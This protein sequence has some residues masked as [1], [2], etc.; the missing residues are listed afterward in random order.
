MHQAGVG[1]VRDVLDLCARLDA[2]CG[3]RPGEQIMAARSP[4]GLAALARQA[5][6]CRRLGLDVP[7]LSEAGVRDRTGVSHPFGLLH[8]PAA[9][10]DPAALTRAL[11]R[12]CA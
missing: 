8:R 12:A 7:E 3:L 1:A 5:R 2:P 4:A 6:A 9:T 11:A 10:L